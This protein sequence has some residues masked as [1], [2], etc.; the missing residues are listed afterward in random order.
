MKVWDILSFRQCISCGDAS[1]QGGIILRVFKNTSH[2][3]CR[4]APW[5]I[6]PF[7]PLSYLEKKFKIW[8]TENPWA[9]EA[10]LS[11]CHPRDMVPPTIF[12]TYIEN[13][14][15]NKKVQY[16]GMK[17]YI[18]SVLIKGEAHTFLFHLVYRLGNYSHFLL[19]LHGL[20]LV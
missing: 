14:G 20:Q 13:L 17:N 18:E 11:L 9:H 16:L 1:S 4:S 12:R 10:N 3:T 19:H 8:S 6:G 5:E 15:V 2:Q 7:G